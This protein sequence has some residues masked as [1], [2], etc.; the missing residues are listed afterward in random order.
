MTKILFENLLPQTSFYALPSTGE[1]ILIKR[2]EQGYFP[3]KKLKHRDYN[4]LNELNG[5]TKAQAEAM[6]AGSLHGWDAPASNPELYNED[7][8]IRLDKIGDIVGENN[9]E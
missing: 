3:Q 2:G 5:I 9:E 7:G 8:L 6:F 1:T 4:E